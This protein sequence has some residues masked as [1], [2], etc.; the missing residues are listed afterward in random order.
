MSAISA[1]RAIISR[2]AQTFEGVG[3]VYFPFS[4]GYGLYPIGGSELLRFGGLFREP[5]ILQVFLLWGIVYALNERMPKVL[6]VAMIVGVTT[7]FSTIGIALLPGI[8]LAWAIYR[9]RTELVSKAAIAVAGVALMLLLT[10]YAPAVGLSAKSEVRET[11]I[12]DRTEASNTGLLNAVENPIGVGLYDELETANSGITLVALAG[13]I[14]IFGFLLAV[15]TYVVPATVTGQNRGA[16]LIAVFPVLLTN[17][18]SQPL[19][20]APLI[21]VLLLARFAPSARRLYE[22][23]V[24]AATSIPAAGKG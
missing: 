4:V 3:D 1:L 15:A 12:T 17:L 13:Q 11:S 21:Y 2:E 5:G 8:L 23:R 6:V 10:F 16:Y 18:L 19:L 24:A 9:I 7:T 22:R 14:G 20:D